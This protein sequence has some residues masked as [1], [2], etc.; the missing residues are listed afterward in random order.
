MT[1]ELRAVRYRVVIKMENTWYV[2]GHP[3]DLDLDGAARAGLIYEGE[4]DG[5]W[6]LTAA[7][8]EN[9]LGGDV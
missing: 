1:N 7:G 8:E 3:T 9:L 6:Y 5:V 4:T 2:D